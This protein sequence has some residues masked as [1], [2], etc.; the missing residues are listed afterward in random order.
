MKYIKTLI[1]SISLLLAFSSNTKERAQ[2]GGE[3][4]EKEFKKI[5]PYKDETSDRHS[6]EEFTI[7][8]GIGINF[9]A[10]K[11]FK[12]NAN[13]V[14][15][16]YFEYI[17]NK[18]GVETRFSKTLYKL[19]DKDKS[20]DVLFFAI[21]GTYDKVIYKNIILR[22]KVG[23]SIRHEST[24]KQLIYKTSYAIELITENVY[25][26]FSLNIGFNLTDKY[27]NYYIGFERL[28]N[29]Y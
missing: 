6:R 1:L 28:F 3:L 23:Y 13:G 21:Y 20:L 18:F 2:E 8:L 4:L 22:P 25:K 29:F 27:S 11:D 17:K 9:D 7:D 19:K 12:R 16:K 15:I 26:D 5:Y 14:Y 24:R 10:H